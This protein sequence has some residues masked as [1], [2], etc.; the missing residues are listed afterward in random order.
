MLL[1]WS[2][3]SLRHLKNLYETCQVQQNICFKMKSILDSNFPWTSYD[4]FLATLEKCKNNFS[5]LYSNIFCVIMESWKIT[6]F[7]QF[8]SQLSVQSLWN[9][10]RMLFTIHFVKI[11]QMR[12][13]FWSI[14]SCIRTEYSP[15]SVRIR[16]NTDQKKLRIST[17]FT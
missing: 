15:Y 3:D 7:W 4:P 13:F 2:F 10:L 14:F 1:T 16:E 5:R 17:L 8:I 6:I 11:V 12:C 9:N